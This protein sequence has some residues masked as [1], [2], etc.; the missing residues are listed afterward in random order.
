MTTAL[1]LL[2]LLG[3]LLSLPGARATPLVAS[4]DPASLANDSNG[5]AVNLQQR[6]GASFLFDAPVE[7]GGVQIWARDEGA[8]GIACRELSLG[9]FQGSP[10]D[11]S[12]LLFSDTVTLDGM[13]QWRSFAP[14]SNLSLGAG[15]YWIELST[16]GTWD[17][18]NE[19]GI[20][21]PGAVR[22]PSFTGPTF[23]ILSDGQW[24]DDSTVWGVEVFGKSLRTQVPDAAA[25]GGL[26]LG[27][28]LALVALR[29]R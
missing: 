15:A 10:G 3:L 25:T 27:A 24:T 9:F 14:P 28:F 19:N 6:L 18:D 22:P 17:L 13:L 5:R 7:I 29:R 1:R 23:H 20:I 21:I 4:V 26:V 16:T 2:G 12:T 11:P 8:E